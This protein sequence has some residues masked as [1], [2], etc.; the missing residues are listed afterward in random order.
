MFKLKIIILV[1]HIGISCSCN[2]FFKEIGYLIV[3]KI[4]NKKIMIIL[5]ITYDTKVNKHFITKKEHEEIK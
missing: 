4:Q 2:Q 3:N 5:N 1:I